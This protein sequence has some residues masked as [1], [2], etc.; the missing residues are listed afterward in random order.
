MVRSGTERPQIDAI[1]WAREA[2]QRGAGEILL[3]SFDRDGTRQ[4]YDLPQLR[5]FSEAV[6]LPII[7]SGG[8][9]SPQH[10][11]DAIQAGADAVLA[12]SI[13]HDGDWSIQAVKDFLLQQ[14]VDCRPTP[15]GF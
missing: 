4:G 14:G 10:L 1:Q 6:Q 12:A 8:A 9:N 7:A 2:E 3:T 5:A 15:P 11:Y 13:F